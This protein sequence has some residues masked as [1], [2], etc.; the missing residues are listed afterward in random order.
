VN[1]TCHTSGAEYL[2]TTTTLSNYYIEQDNT[3]LISSPLVTVW[4]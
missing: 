2:K 4:S 3:G 1:Y